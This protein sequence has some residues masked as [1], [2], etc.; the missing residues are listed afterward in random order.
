MSSVLTLFNYPTSALSAGNLS[1][2]GRRAKLIK[3]PR[4]VTGLVDSDQGARHRISMYDKAKQIGLPSSFVE[5]RHQATHEE[6]PSLTVLRRAVEKS[7][8]W[9]VSSIL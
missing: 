1:E 9:L 5:M 3:C 2:V 6:F 8:S 7:L 4:F